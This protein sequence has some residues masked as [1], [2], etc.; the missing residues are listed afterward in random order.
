M[1]VVQVFDMNQDL[2]YRFLLPL[3]PV[4]L[5]SRLVQEQHRHK[6]GI[7]PQLPVVQVDAV[8]VADGSDGML[9]AAL[10]GF[11]Q[12]MDEPVRMLPA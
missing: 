9:E 11:R 10:F 3:R 8:P 1:L 12:L 7:N 2:A 5:A 6:E 4:E